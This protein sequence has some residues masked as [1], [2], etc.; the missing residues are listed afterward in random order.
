MKKA[1]IFLI[2]ILFIFGAIATAYAEEKVKLPGLKMSFDFPDSKDWVIATAGVDYN[3]PLYAPLKEFDRGIV[4][5]GEGAYLY[6]FTRENDVLSITRVC[7]GTE[8]VIFDLNLLS[9]AEFNELMQGA[10]KAFT[11]NGVTIPDASVY[12]HSQAKFMCFPYH[13][14]RDMDIYGKN[15]ITII[16]GMM[17]MITYFN[18]VPMSAEQEHMVQDIIDSIRFDEVLQKPAGLSSLECIIWAAAFA[19]ILFIGLTRAGR[20]AAIQSSL[21]PEQ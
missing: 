4:N 12:K 18:N 5:S 2:I 3:D 7:E 21:L 14:S 11:D 20:K 10:K 17:I 9:D 13:D 15:Y 19:A 1:F 16:N 8:S 6:A